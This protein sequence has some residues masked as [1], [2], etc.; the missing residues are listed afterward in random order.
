[1]QTKFKH[2][3]V[4]YFQF[5][6]QSMGNGFIFNLV[7]GFGVSFL[8]GLGLT[9]FIPLL[10]ITEDKGS[11]KVDESNG[12]LQ[13]VLKIFEKLGLSLSLYNILILMVLLFTVKGII[14]F[15]QSYAQVNLKRKFMKKI[16]NRLT[17]SL[18]NISYTG[19][20]NL[21]AGTIQNTLTS[22][23]SRLLV[24]ISMYLGSSK[25]VVMLITYMTL[26]FLANWKFAVLVAVGAFI[27]NFFFQNVFANV[28]K[29]SGGISQKG[30]AFNSYLL[31]A[32][33]YFKYL[34]ATNHFSIYSKK[35]KGIIEDIETLNQK[36]GFNQSLTASIREPMIVLIVA[37]VIIF[38]VKF[39]GS[40]LSSIVLSILLFYRSL[41]YLMGL[42]T[43][44]QAFMQNVGAIES[45]YGLTSQMETMTEQTT[46]VTAPQIQ[47]YISLENVSFSYGTKKVI[48]NI[49][50]NIKKN[51]AIALVGESGS[52]KTTLANIITG[53]LNPGSGEITLDGIPLNTLNLNSY[54]NKI[55]YISQEAVIFRDD[56]YNNITF[57]A[58][59][60]IENKKRFWEVVNMTSLNDFVE[61]LPEKEQ[62]MLG[63][64]GML[65]SGGQ[66]QRISIARELFKKVDIMILDEATSAL[67]SETERFIQENIE[68]LQGSYTMII[69]AHRLSTVKNVDQIYLLDNGS[70]VCHGQFNEML[71][72]SERFKRMVSLQ[73]V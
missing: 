67:D 73:Q 41:S 45:I 58:E 39:M 5:F 19:F 3:L 25:G 24:A 34:K 36:I 42:Q 10:Q 35:L 40:S 72:Q 14:S 37:L 47:N 31:Q 69:I 43:G 9:M 64:N 22:D 46:N 56:V 57:W 52:G 38:Q 55:G 26:A 33:H 2:T 8:D 15:I 18:Q 17:D 61:Q 50:I 71:E 60:T 7:L 48:N 27:S 29:Y 59:P 28:K 68:K 16:R 49:S 51:T 11:A 63:D 20:T 21:D 30:S 70:V 6:Y 32:V 4:G 62:T 23:V 1:M 54:R 13:Y 44:W 12:I 53:L 65:I 66:K